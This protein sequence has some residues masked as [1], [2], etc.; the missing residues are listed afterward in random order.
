MW[1]EQIDLFQF[2]VVFAVIAGVLLATNYDKQP[3]LGAIEGAVNKLFHN[4]TD[5]FYTGRVM[6]LFFDGV[7]IDCTPSDDKFSSAAC[8]TLEEQNVVQK[9]DENHLKFSVFGGVNAMQFAFI[10]VLPMGV[11][12]YSFHK[13]YQ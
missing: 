2:A 13:I 7:S 6:D 3:L 11:T 1:F 4:P 12:I 5:A 8:M 9:I 10:F